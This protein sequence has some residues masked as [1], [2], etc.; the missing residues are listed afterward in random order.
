V[1]LQCGGAAVRLDER[2]QVHVQHVL[3]HGWCTTR[4]QATLLH[5]L[6]VKVQT[7]GAMAL[8]VSID[9]QHAKA[10]ASLKARGHYYSEHP[11]RTFLTSTLR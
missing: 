10:E 5:G 7:A 11:S 6:Q 4:I 2:A 8:G 9:T 3:R 1:E